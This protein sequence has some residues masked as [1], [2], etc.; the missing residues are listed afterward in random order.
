MPRRSWQLYLLLCIRGRHMRFVSINRILPLFCQKWA[1]Q[2]LL[3]RNLIPIVVSYL[4]HLSSSG[5]INYYC[6]DVVIYNCQ[7][8]A[9]IQLRNELWSV[10]I[11]LIRY[12]WTGHQKSSYWIGEQHK[13][14][15]QLYVVVLSLVERSGIQDRAQ[16]AYWLGLW[17]MKRWWM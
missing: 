5:T 13:C 3:P 16:M 14:L 9:F 11:Y 8:G 4:D 2:L 7:L 6:T 1:N 12:K 15:T 10:I 17:G